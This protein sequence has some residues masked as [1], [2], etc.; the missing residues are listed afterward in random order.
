MY[1][2]ISALLSGWIG[3][4]WILHVRLESF[5]HLPVS[6]QLCDTHDVQ[7]QCIMHS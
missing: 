5:A 3:I 6:L 1:T 2:F 7:I 4:H